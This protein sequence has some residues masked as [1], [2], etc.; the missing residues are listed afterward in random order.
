MT[1]SL[2]HALG[3][4]PERGTW[5]TDAPE[6]IH[7]AVIS[8]K[9]WRELGSPSDIVG[10]P[11]TL[12]A[13][14]YVIKGVAQPWFQFPPSYSGDVWF[15]L[16]P[17][18]SDRTNRQ[19]HWLTCLAKMK[20]GVTEAQAR[21]DMVRIAA[22]LEHEY[23]ATEANHTTG[24]RPLLV[25]VTERVRPV[26]LLLLGAAI[27]LLLIACG[28]V[29]SLLLAR[30]VGR[31]QETAVRVATGASA[32]RLAAQYVAE[33]LF[34]ALAGAC[35]G[36]LA[37]VA[38][39]K[40]VLHF[41]SAEIPRADQVGLDGNVAVITLGC[42]ILC[43]VLFS[44]APLW[45][46]LRVSPNAVLTN[47]ARSTA[48]AGT[49]RV[50]GTF[51]TAQ[52]ALSCA[53]L[54]VA[55]LCVQRLGDL[56]T[57]DTGFDYRDVTT[58]YTYIPVSRFA[59]EAARAQYQTRLLR[60]VVGAHLARAAAFT[61]LLPFS[62]SSADIV[63]IP[64]HRD[65]SHLPFT[66]QM[67]LL[68][69]QFRP[70]SP[71]IFAA[72]RIPL[73]SGRYLTDADGTSK[74][75][76]LVIDETVARR[77]WPHTSPLGHTMV[78]AGDSDHTDYKVVGV[79]NDVQDRPGE[80]APGHIYV[81][82]QSVWITLLPA[83]WALRT[84]PGER[85]RL[86]AIEN[87]IHRV[88]PQLAVFGFGTL[89]KLKQ[90]FLGNNRLQSSMTLLF[91]LTALVLAVLG[92]YG[93]VSYTVRQR[94]R[95]MGTRLALG[96]TSNGLLVLVL[97]QAMVKATIGAAAGVV[98]VFVSAPLLRK[99]DLNIG[100]PGPFVWSVL[101]VVLSTAAAATI[102]AWR[103]S[104]LSPAIALRD[105]PESFWRRA[106]IGYL[107]VA[108]TVSSA[109]GMDSVTTNTAEAALLAEIA[110]ST[111]QADS[112]AAAICTTLTIVVR[113]VP[114]S[115]A[116]LLVR[117]AENEPFRCISAVPETDQTWTL[118]F[119][120]M[121]LTRL[122]HYYPAVPFTEADLEALDRWSQ[123]SGSGHAAEIGTLRSIG[124]A[125]VVP[126]ALKS[127]ISG[128]L[129]VRTG[130]TETSADARTMRLLRSV[131]SQLALM[132][133]N[134]HLTDRIVEQERLR[135]E[136]A[137]ASEVQKRLFPEKAPEG[138]S[139]QLVGY[140]LPARGVGGDYYDFL[141]IG[142]GRLGIALADVAGKGIAAALVMSVVQ[143]SLRSL[144]EDPAMSLSQLTGKVNRLLCASTGPNSYAT[145]F[146]ARLDEQTRRL[147]YVNGGHNPPFLLRNH[148][149][150]T[151]E[152]LR[153]GGMII[154]M[155]PFSQYEEGSV[156][157]ES[158]DVLM[159]YTDGVSEAHNPAEE[160]FGEERLK[161]V[162]RR[163]GHL[164]AEQ[165]SEAILGD[166]QQWMS[167]APQHDDLTFVL[168]KVP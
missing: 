131:A 7:S 56:S 51:I 45:Q 71:G 162:L 145:F 47:G 106:R 137:L 8:D 157:L 109:I 73:I 6:D 83:E 75:P 16:E 144:A 97:K 29:A 94:T 5:F 37:S 11:I 165:M 102:P 54:V 53:L 153:E 141:R 120:T 23:P 18:A 12:N 15:P 168:M 30:S 101:A 159:L 117:R 84:G 125:V 167:D 128:I 110:E 136:L 33:G 48:S 89:E 123:E 76:G 161:D 122:S 32:G 64:D 146:Y 134:S 114:A 1:P 21:A 69:Y 49:Q 158:G 36:L 98:L 164:P 126:V 103:A 129:F 116:V 124:P 133:E 140:C 139:A 43:G 92:V 82:Y 156:Q 107:R 85:V 50:L 65:L 25:S 10:K 115:A 61:G 160:E 60:A 34:L 113:R 22:E 66:E 31:A 72:L 52:I 63:I 41:A 166:L 80:P 58:F 151:I 152:E 121:L 105:A 118:P 78:F 150:G 20:P 4:P 14:S 93:V 19:E 77:L 62:R 74:P 81:T 68:D 70:V 130:D 3:V 13:V 79:V 111:R 88:D 91:G 57:M 40:L 104:L 149:S 135:R 24:L 59:N 42:A 155:F 154:G 100:A 99:L 112:F 148:Q 143:A 138:C 28:N 46:A 17:S 44:L 95:E 142:T 67:R 35:A 132:L 108:H 127:G 87:A 39:V 163:Y 27:V 2:I 147:T 86:S 9:L 119:D 26:F 55:I 96:E 90:E 38:L